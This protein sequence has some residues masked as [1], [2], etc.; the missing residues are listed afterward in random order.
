MSRSDLSK[1]WRSDFESF[2]RPD[3][4]TFRNSDLGFI[5][6]VQF[7]V[8]ILVLPNICNGKTKGL[9]TLPVVGG[10]GEGGGI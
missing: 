3:L 6:R 1:S 10:G 2:R 8:F 9:G 7:L 5:V 4:G